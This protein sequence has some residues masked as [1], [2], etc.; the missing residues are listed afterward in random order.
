MLLLDVKTSLC[1]DIFI[2]ETL[3]NRQLIES[4]SS[5]SGCVILSYV[6]RFTFVFN[7]FEQISCLLDVFSLFVSV[8]FCFDC[9]CEFCH[10]H[11]NIQ[12]TTSVCVQCECDV[13]IANLIICHGNYMYY[14]QKDLL[15][16]KF[17]YVLHDAAPRVSD[18]RLCKF[19]AI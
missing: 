1:N 16:R 18:M 11:V 6:D 3:Q 5:L 8:F 12:Y 15:R 10:V 9:G 2:S 13:L 7:V 19:K 14:K 4:P 17:V